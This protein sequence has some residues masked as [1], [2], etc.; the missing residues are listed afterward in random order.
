MPLKNVRYR[1][2]TTDKGTRVRL[3][4][5]GNE[6]VEAKNMMTGAMHTEKEFKEDKKARRP[7]RTTRT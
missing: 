5:R 6:V 4:F 3:A 1:I 2:M 7:L